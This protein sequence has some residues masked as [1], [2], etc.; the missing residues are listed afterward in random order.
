MTIRIMSLLCIVGVTTCIQRSAAQEGHII[1]AT[2]KT[3]RDRFNTPNGYVRM[4]TDGFGNYLRTLPL[5]EHGAAVHLY[6]GDLKSNQ[7]AHAAVI[8]MDVGNYNL[9]QCA[10]AIMRL[11]SEYLYKHRQFDKIHF[12]FTNGFNATYSKW[13]SGYRISI[14]GDQ[15]TWV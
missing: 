15:C 9:Q 1:N 3:V 2:G 10:D 7:Q 4:S 13:R 14:K 8:S 6:N 5:Q 12:N 11:R